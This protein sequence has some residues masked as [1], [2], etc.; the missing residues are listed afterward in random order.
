MGKIDFKKLSQKQLKSLKAIIPPRRP[1]WW[2]GY[3][4]IKEALLDGERQE[5]FLISDIAKHGCSGGVPGLTYYV[6]TTDFFDCFEHDVWK[7]VREAADA[8]GESVFFLL[9][10]DIRGPTAFKNSMV[11][12]AVEIAAQEL[13]AQE[14]A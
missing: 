14:D 10:K 2:L 13:A 5:V 6:D 12:L 9:D 3:T 11:W 1:K 8:A 4:D 7:Y